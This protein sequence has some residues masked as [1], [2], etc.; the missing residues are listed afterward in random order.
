M[1]KKLVLGD[2][3]LGSEI[4]KQTGWD[5]ISRKKD[6]FDITKFKEWNFFLDMIKCVDEM[7]DTDIIINCIGYT[8][9]YDP[10]PNKSI[11]INYKSVIELVDF[12]NLC[13]KKL[14]HISTDYIYGFSESE[15]K[16]TDVPVHARNWYS[17]SKLLADA[18]VQYFCNDYLLIR[19]S[20][21]PKPFPYENAIITQKGNFD[22]VDDIAKLIIQLIEKDASGIYNVGT[23]IKTIYELALETKNVEK[24]NKL[25]DPSM[26]TDITMNLEK[27][28]NKLNEN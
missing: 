14:V 27:M 8:N 24:T 28:R 4:V 13:E 18:Y 15:A 9:T 5:Y 21:K 22:Y 7:L 17:Y 12:C 2:G 23:E 10:K 20:F 19:T 1:N 26:P 3:L 16:E 25:L 6:G 11:E